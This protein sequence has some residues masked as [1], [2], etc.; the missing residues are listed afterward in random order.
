MG[1]EDRREGHEASQG[2]YRVVRHLCWLLSRWDPHRVGLLGQ[3]IRIWDARTGNEVMKPLEGHTCDITSVAFSPDGN[4]IVS[5]S[6][7]N[8]IRIWD[9]RTSEVM[10]PILPSFA[11]CHGDGWLRGAHQELILWVFPEWRKF[12]HWGRCILIIGESHVHLDLLHY[13][14]GLEWIRCISNS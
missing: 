11:S 3:T 8:T 4:H 14:H 2:T 12:L 6:R 10:N 1:C 7:D 5:G 9:T 13:V